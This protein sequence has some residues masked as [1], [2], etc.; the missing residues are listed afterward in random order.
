MNVGDEH[1]KDPTT[2]DIGRW[3]RLQPQEHVGC[4]CGGTWMANGFTQTAAGTF[5]EHLTCSRCGERV[6]K[7]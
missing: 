6:R 3:R 4:D 7:G 1:C 5:V 2:H